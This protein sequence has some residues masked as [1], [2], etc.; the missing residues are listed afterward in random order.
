MS[1]NHLIIGLGGTG[2]KIIRALRKTIFQEYRAI[3]PEGVNLEYLYVDSSDEMM[4]PDDPTWRVLGKSVQLG[5][6][7]QLLI[8]DAN[9]RSRL[10]NINNYPGIKDWIGSPEEWGNILRSIVGVTLGGQKRRLGRFLF[11]CKADQFRQQLQNQ[12][13]QLQNQ[14]EIAVTFHICAG[15]AGGTGSGC[16]LDVIAQVRDNYPDA[17]TYRIIVYTLL[18]DR[19]P[20]PNWDTGNYHANGYAALMELNAL[21]VGAYHPFDVTGAKGRL[22][23]QDPFNGCYIFTN[24]NENGLF[25]DVGSEVPNI[26]ANFL[27]QKLVSVKNVQWETLRRMENAENGDGSPETAPGARQGERSKRFLTFGIK[28]LAIPEEEIREYLTFSFARQAAL[29]LQFN[30]WSDALSFADEPRNQSFQEIVKQSDTQQRWLISDDHLRLSVGILE[31]ERK[32]PRWKSINVTWQDIIPQFRSFIRETYAGNP[33]VWLDELSLLCEKRYAQEYRELGVPRFYE[34]KKADRKEH[35]REIRA[36]IEKDLIE[37]WRNGVQSMSDIRRL[38]EALVNSLQER[39]A[40]VDDKIGTAMRNEESA[41]QRVAATAKE[42]AGMGLLAAAMG[43]RDK[44][45]DTQGNALQEQYTYR[46]NAEA[47][48]FAKGLMQALVA[49]L[50]SLQGEVDRAASMIA[51][52]TELFTK[53]IASRCNDEGSTDM[54]QQLV[55]FYKPEAVKDF[56]RALVKDKE[57]QFKQAKAVRDALLAPLGD[58][59]NFAAFNARISKERFVDILETRCEENAVEAHN[60]MVSDKKDNVRIL[61]DSIVERLYQQ[62]GGDLEAVRRYIRELVSMAGNYVT[63]KSEEVSKTGE[64]IP[65]NV[66]TRISNFTIIVP[67]SAVHPEFTTALYDAFRRSST[68]ANMEFIPSKEIPSDVKPNEI[69]LI[70]V[71]NLF[72]L[73]YLEQTAFLKEKYE[74]RINGPGAA[75][76]KLELHSEGDGATLPP[77]FVPTTR[78]VVEDGLPYVLLGRAIDLIQE[79]QNPATGAKTLALVT[80]D[81]DGFDNEPVP[82]GATLTTS[83]GMLDA[84]AVRLIR[85][86]VDQALNTTYLHIDRRAELQK[87]ILA[88]VESVKAERGNNIQDDVYRR[89]L[90][91]G[92]RAVVLL[93]PKV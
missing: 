26:V 40:A 8:T 84:A 29:Q 52:A 27:Y 63:F 68:V 18:P 81:E 75:R 60:I 17:R 48:R 72:P 28:R 45:F 79:M 78:N 83:I 50:N 4:N 34:T 32:N 70:S 47:W 21:S 44:L 73:R 6:S 66:P 76:I 89:F 13:R 46:T 56:T 11:A 87:S 43:K 16:L 59:P 49:E 69:T 5:N 62:F 22:D 67:P 35:L 10:E 37:D 31:D 54:K 92:K 24:E 53:S 36:R 58:N 9:L 77:L 55:K 82:L 90:D 25:V 12:V 91:A 57:G 80:K 14:G 41:A 20:K 65:A 86:A 7:S 71:T 3:D 19:Y 74:Q 51:D 30:N 61:G 85:T 93:K 2:G 39:L 64:G 42:W 15:L 88:L 33:R 38:L 1:K 23:M